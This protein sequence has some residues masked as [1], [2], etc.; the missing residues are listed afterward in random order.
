MKHIVIAAILLTIEL[1][2]G[3]GII[4]IPA[5]IIAAIVLISGSQRFGARLQVAALY[6]CVSIL[7]FTW[8]VTT[9]T[10]PRAERLL[11][12]LRVSS[13]KQ[14]TATIQHSSTS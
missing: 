13:S 14:N 6:L 1:L 12:L 11:L 2:L 8:I 7:S 10:L 5:L 4:G 9:Y 3:L